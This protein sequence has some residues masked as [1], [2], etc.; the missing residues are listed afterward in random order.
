MAWR[1]IFNKFKFFGWT[2]P[3]S[4]NQPVETTALHKGL[5][6]ILQPNKQTKSLKMKYVT[7]APL[8]PPNGNATCSFV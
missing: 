3:L 5:I 4:H 8:Q 7:Y 1:Y 2:I 6:S